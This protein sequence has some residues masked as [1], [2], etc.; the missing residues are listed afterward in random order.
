M[1]RKIIDY[2]IK[3][4]KELYKLEEKVM[5]SIQSIWEPFGSLQITKHDMNDGSIVWHYYRPIVVYD[6]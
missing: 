4:D 5:K 1:N 2:R 3:S 6:D